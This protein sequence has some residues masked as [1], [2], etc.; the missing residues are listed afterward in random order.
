MQYKN[1]IEAIYISL[2]EIQDLISEMGVEQEIRIIDIDLATDKIRHIYDL[3]NH[4]K[5]EVSGQQNT[6]IKS[7]GSSQRV[8]I[9]QV[10]ENTIEFDLNE[11]NDSS[12]HSSEKELDTLEKNI[13]PAKESQ[14]NQA[15]IDSRVKMQSGKKFL[16]DTFEKRT[17]S[18]NEELSKTINPTK[19][20]EKLTSKP[21][22]NIGSALGLNEKFEIINHLFDGNKDKYEHTLQVFN[23]ASDF[24]EA[25]EYIA[26]DLQWDMENQYV[27]KILEL[28]R[29]KLIVKKN[30]Q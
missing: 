29:R 4:L 21:I 10:E 11:D 15:E 8:E 22:I 20:T 13:A 1:T 24:N 3:M 17:S 5:V 16:G 30:E 2:A 26:H 12:G 9:E 19:L 14:K 23:A 28:I 18:I 7:S 6:E 27:Q 25:Y